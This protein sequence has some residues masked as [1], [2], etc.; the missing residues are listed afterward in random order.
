MTKSL[1]M[2]VPLTERL[3]PAKLSRQ[4]TEEIAAWTSI[5]HCAATELDARAHG[6]PA[7]PPRHD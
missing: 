5:L 2:L 7:N 1:L 6:Q 4:T 3:L